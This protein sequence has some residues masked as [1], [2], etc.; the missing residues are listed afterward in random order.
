MHNEAS[1]YKL[2]VVLKHE[3]GEDGSVLHFTGLLP[4]FD[5]SG[6]F[7]ENDQK[8]V[9][10]TYA[11]PASAIISRP[12]EIAGHLKLKVAK[13]DRGFFK[14]EE[15]NEG[16]R[17]ALSIDIE[18][19]EITPSFHVVEVKRSRGDTLEYQKILKQDIRPALKEIVWA[20]QGEQQH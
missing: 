1:S 17:G 6:L 19:F 2:P 18:I 12:E 20:W 9:Q 16:I 13:K 11:K 3:I 4:W 5:L 10:F 8:E 7:V 15:S 14:L